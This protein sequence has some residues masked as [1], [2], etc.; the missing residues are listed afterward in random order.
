MKKEEVT[1]EKK[2]TKEESKL[3]A[4]A[5]KLVAKNNFIKASFGGFAGSGKTYTATQFIIG[6]YKEY[7]CKKPILIID[8]E[9]GSRFLIPMFQQAGIQVYV[10][11]TVKLA[12]V[13][14]AMQLLKDNEIDF[15]FIDTLTKVWYNYIKDYKDKNRVTF[16]T[17]QDWGKVLPSWQE[18]FSDKFVE[19]EGN[20]V[21]TGR[22][23]FQYEKEEDTKDES[24]RIIK[25]GQ[26]VKSGVKMK[27]AGETPFEPDLN[28]WMEL[29]QELTGDGL[30]VY[31]EAQIMKDRSGLIDGQT[32]INPKYENFQSVVK[33][34]L[35][36]PVGEVIGAT[37]TD[38]LA[39]AENTE[40]Y[41]EKQSREIFM[42]EIKGTFE[43]YGFGTSKEDKQLKATIAD[44][45]FGTTATEALERLNSRELEKGLALIKAILNSLDDADDKLSYIKSINIK[46]L[47]IPVEDNPLNN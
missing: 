45:V 1:Q 24:G 35:N 2:Q 22:G 6:A 32:I 13:L 31:R 3:M 30:K 14:E 9:K 15:L 20:I 43:K 17:L 11:D 7:N 23:G 44:K 27:L 38:N 42:A 41:K 25:K 16:M 4:F 19:A 36:V 26:F 34:L 5:S 39:P 12:D 18:A 29:Q 37:N 46:E 40:W 28:I 8:N 21:F 10:K 47:A 33:F